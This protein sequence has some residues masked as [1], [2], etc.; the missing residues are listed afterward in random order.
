MLVAAAINGEVQVKGLSLFSEQADRNIMKALAAAGVEV[1]QID[2]KISVSKSP[3][4]A[5]EF[6]ATHCPDLFPPL[7]VLAAACDGV[8]KIKGVERLHNKESNRGLTLQQELGKLGIEIILDGNLMLVKGGKIAGGTI[9]SHHDH[10]I[11]I[12]AA[13]A[14][15]IAEKP[16]IIQNAECVSKSWPSFFEDLE[17]LNVKIVK[18]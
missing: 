6:D 10:R 13:V 9:F 4:L 3:L 17:L 7:A 5:F 16:V 2:D 1:N 11:A 15:I 18:L 12:A 14:G 8:S